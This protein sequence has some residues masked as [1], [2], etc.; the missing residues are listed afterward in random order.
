[1][2]RVSFRVNLHSIV[3]LDVKDLHA[4]SRCHIWSLSDSNRV[5]THNHLVFKRTLNHLAKLAKG[6]IFLMNV[7]PDMYIYSLKKESVAFLP[8]GTVACTHLAA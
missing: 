6:L 8:E 2:S 1:M 7:L 4:R 5:G 3:C